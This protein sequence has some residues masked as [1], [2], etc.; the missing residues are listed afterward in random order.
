MVNSNTPG[1]HTDPWLDLLRGYITEAVEAL[2]NHGV[3]VS[4]SW[5]DPCDPRDATI[6][7]SLA[8]KTN[9]LVWDEE[10]GWRTGSYEGG[11]Q[12]ERT[13]LTGTAHLGGSV[14][15]DARTMA[16]RLVIGETGPQHKFRSYADVRDG[17]DEAL[18]QRPNTPAVAG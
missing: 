16:H 1:M 7:Y 4:R 9:A 6:V 15:P 12:G 2:E 3:P 17:L 8:G 14:L 11:E 13:R 18:R 5:L 10:Y